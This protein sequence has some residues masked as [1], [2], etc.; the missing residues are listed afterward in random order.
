MNFDKVHNLNKFLSNIAIIKPLR[1]KLRIFLDTITIGFYIKNIEKKTYEKYLLQ[2]GYNLALR[3]GNGDSL[4]TIAAL[5][6]FEKTYKA[7]VKL[8]IKPAQEYLMKIFDI[9][10]Y[11]I[12]ED[13]KNKTLYPI[14]INEKPFPKKGDIW[15]VHIRY[16]KQTREKTG[17][18]CFNNFREEIL[19]LLNL[20]LT[21]KLN[22]PTNQHKISEELNKKVKALN[23][24]ILFIPE[25]NLKSV[26]NLE[27]WEKL[28]SLLKKAG[29]SVI[30]NVICKENYLKNADL[31]ENFKM[32]DLIALGF[33]CKAVVSIR[34]GMCDILNSRGKDLFVFD[35]SQANIE[36]KKYFNLNA[37]FN[38]ND[39]NEYADETQISPEK[40]A[41]KLLK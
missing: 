40:L 29:Y 18:K 5:P 30:S 14:N 23:K 12:V 39:I 10:D 33:R 3:E 8:F 36:D 31:N 34:N 41:E 24:T 19:T 38:R 25:A 13:F 26:G 9:K 2:D 21:T 7:K 16:N 37:M 4:L 1:K 22:F 28:A 11:F 27:Y 32:E 35:T 15:F 20:P 6:A 17:L